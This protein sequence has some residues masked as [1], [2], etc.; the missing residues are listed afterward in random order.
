[1]EGGGNTSHRAGY[2]FTMSFG[3]R[4]P[5]FDG[6]GSTLHLIKNYA[7]ALVHDSESPQ[8]SRSQDERNR[9]ASSSR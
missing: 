5:L 6:A 2:E 8:L 1:M 9:R 7:I 3:Y 4:Q